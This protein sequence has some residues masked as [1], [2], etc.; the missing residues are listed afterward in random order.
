MK[1]S[2][3]EKQLS[4]CVFSF[5]V[6][7]CGGGSGGGT[8][9]TPTPTP[10][11]TENV[12]PTASA[13]DDQTVSEGVTVDLVG[14]GT[15]SDGTVDGYEWAQT[16]GSPV[17][18]SDSSMASV[19]FTAPMVSESE[20]LTFELTVTDSD[21]ATATD[22]V[23]VEVSPLPPTP[24]VSISDASTLE[25]D[26]VDTTLSFSVILSEPAPFDLSIPYRSFQQTAT[27]GKDYLSVAGAISVLAG[28]SG[29]EVSVTVKADRVF[30]ADEQFQVVLIEGEGFELDKSMAV[31]TITDDDMTAQGHN[32]SLMMAFH[33]LKDQ[34][35]MDSLSETGMYDTF[36][37]GDKSIDIDADGDEDLLVFSYYD[38][39][40]NTKNN[41]IRIFLNDGEGGLTYTSSELK[42]YARNIDVADINKDGLEDVFITSHGD[43]TDNGLAG[44]QDYMMLQGVDGLLIDITAASVPQGLSK[45]HSACLGD[46]NNDGWIDAFGGD[47]D[48]YYILKN[49]DGESFER[50][51]DDPF[52][53]YAQYPADGFTYCLV[54]DFT[55]DG[56]DDLLLGGSS[57]E[58]SVDH[59][60]NTIGEAH[61]LYRGGSDT[62]SGLSFDYPNDFIPAPF[63]RTLGG[64]ALLDHQATLQ[65]VAF[66]INADGCQEVASF[67]TD[68]NNEGN[69]H[70]FIN[71]C[72]G[73]LLLA[74]TVA[75]LPFASDMMNIVDVDHDGD[76]DLVLV[77][78]ESNFPVSSEDRLSSRAVLINDGSGV[79]TARQGTDED[80]AHIPLLNAVLWGE[81][82]SP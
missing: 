21:G 24:S 13:G 63:E 18:L 17:S 3:L 25:G 76:A 77:A 34:I 60:G 32:H 62:D 39:Q 61:A 69:V 53:P 40:P 31:G 75:G 74:Q 64:D 59:L 37:L 5:L 47:F 19:S 58:A 15:D 43:H 2:S 35:F 12:A 57:S 10:T 49:V 4:L 51:S 70:V 1:I 78:G 79:F 48:D 67:K 29:G 45:T 30:E 14:S 65:M 73:G 27:K 22:S 8:A 54:S 20:T 36:F 72:S 41:P 6:T 56:I 28:E 42:T 82:E 71:D 52:S 9:P 26:D 23:N 11:P 38:E 44:A 7:A 68:Y 55:G 33:Q 16:A 66:D 50:S 81:E 46:F 80:I